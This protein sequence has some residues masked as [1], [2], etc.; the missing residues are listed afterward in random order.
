MQPPNTILFGYHLFHISCVD[1]SKLINELGL[2]EYLPPHRQYR[3]NSFT[4]SLNMS[5]NKTSLIGS[6]QNRGY[7]RASLFLFVDLFALNY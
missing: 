6:L 3:I 7:V 1:E 2:L 5:G 4:K